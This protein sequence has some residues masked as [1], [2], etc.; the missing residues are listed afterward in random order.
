M[1]LQT[2][3]FSDTETAFRAERIGSINLLVRKKKY[4]YNQL[5]IESIYKQKNAKHL[6]LPA[7][8]V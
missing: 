4:F 2:V 7:S 6:L 1:F 8:P 5:T 3:L